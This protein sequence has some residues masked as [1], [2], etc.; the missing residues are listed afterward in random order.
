MMSLNR[1]GQWREANIFLTNLSRNITKEM[2]DAMQESAELVLKR[3]RERIDSGDSDWKPLEE[4]TVKLKGHDTIY[5]ESGWLKKNLDIR[6]LTN[7]QSGMGGKTV[8]IGAS[9]WKTHPSVARAGRALK[10]SDLMTYLEY[11]TTRM[12]GRP[13]LVPVFK[14][15]NS[16]VIKIFKEAM[17]YMVKR[18]GG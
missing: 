13:L 3:L 18:S 1:R 10:F 16:E 2:D 12:E 6:K 9:P 17:F 7:M 15:V 5:I 14:A 11:G 4:R 8:I